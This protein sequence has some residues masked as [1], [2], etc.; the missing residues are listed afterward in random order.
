MVLLFWLSCACVAYV[1]VGYPALMA[2]WVR[3]RGRHSQSGIHNRA[4]TA[5]NPQLGVSIVLAARNEGA[6]LAARLDNFLRL[7]YEGARQIIVVSDGSTDDTLE[8]LAKYAPAVEVVAMPSSGKAAALNAGVARA[9]HDVL[10]FADARQM[11]APDALRELVAPFADPT[12]GAVTGEL[13]LDVEAPERRGMAPDRRAHPSSR[14]GRDA[15]RRTG[16]DRRR[17]V[18]STIADGV[19]LYWRYEKAIRRLESAVFSTL[20]ATGAIYAMRRALWTPLPHDTI[21]DDVLAPMRAVL[22]GYRTVFHERARAF[23]RAAR[24]GDA[25]ARRKIRTL[26]GNYQ[27]LWL[28]PRLL[29]PWRNPVW[30]QYV[31]HKVGRLLV[32]YA[33]IGLMTS[34]MALAEQ[35][36]LYAV[37]LA[38][39]CLFYLLA[40]YGA[41]LD[42][43]GQLES[44]S[45]PALAERWGAAPRPARRGAV[46]V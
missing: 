17:T 41:W 12:V 37:A 33:L 29:L 28:E 11:F 24:D 43:R 34:S 26:A 35:S 45:T 18:Q 6:R 36:V 7:E 27:I 21:L 2:L 23:D 1:Y 44:R 40:G 31:S 20:G 46:N 15:E 30:L 25:E 3:V 14:G 4:S 5:R 42:L 38:V 22:A 16:V 39:Q 10:V 13:I 8:V 9:R 32:P 19:G